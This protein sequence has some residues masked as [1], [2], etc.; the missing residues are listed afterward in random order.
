MSHPVLWVTCSRA[1]RIQ[2][3]DVA[4][5]TDEKVYIKLSQNLDPQ[6]TLHGISGK[7]CKDLVKFIRQQGLSIGTE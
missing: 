6:Y 3:L 7:Q 2:R 5:Y 1:Y 4:G